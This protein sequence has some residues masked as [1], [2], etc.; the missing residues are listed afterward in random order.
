MEHVREAYLRLP[1][2]GKSLVGLIAATALFVA[3]SLLLWVAGTCLITFVPLVL[4]LARA[5]GAS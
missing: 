1:L 2:W 3:S 4:M 5:A